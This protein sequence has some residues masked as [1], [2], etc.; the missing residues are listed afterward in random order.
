MVLHGRQEDIS[1]GLKARLSGLER[2]RKCRLGIFGHKSRLV[3]YCT[4][5]F[6]RAVQ[7]LSEIAKLPWYVV[8]TLG[9]KGFCVRGHIVLMKLGDVGGN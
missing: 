9:L 4:A 8:L 1:L 6:Y 2:R 3:N 7:R 5:Q